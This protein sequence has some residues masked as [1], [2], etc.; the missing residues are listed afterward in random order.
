MA[1][2]LRVDALVAVACR[3]TSA[4]RKSR[5]EEVEVE[6]KEEDS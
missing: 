1:D 4:F 6:E 5:E 2:G 3:S